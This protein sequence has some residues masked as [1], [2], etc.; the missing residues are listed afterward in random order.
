MTI[1]ELIKQ[2]EESCGVKIPYEIQERREGDVGSAYGNIDRALGELG[3]KPEK[4]L[5]D[6]CKLS[7]P[8]N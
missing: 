7:R 1:L 5:D 2:F 6:M 3:W 8:S 4:S